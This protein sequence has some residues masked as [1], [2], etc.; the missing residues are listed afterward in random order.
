M[1][2]RREGASAIEAALAL[3]VLLVLLFA[4]LDW[5]WYLFE[6]LTVVR[7]AHAGVRLAVGV[8]A[9]ADPESVATGAVEQALEAY[10]IPADSATIDV[11]LA[12][13]VLT[14]DV[15]VDFQALVG[16]IPTPDQLHARTEAAWYGGVFEGT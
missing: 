10:G 11:V 3:P 2:R 9:S 13:D 15:R 7:S 8:E 4:I 12:E 1:R 14:V 6:W 16:V 5:S